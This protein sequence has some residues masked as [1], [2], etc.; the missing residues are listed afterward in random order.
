MCLGLAIREDQTAITLGGPDTT[1]RHLVK[2]PEYS[3]FLALELNSPRINY[4]YFYRN[5]KSGHLLGLEGG[6]TVRNTHTHTPARILINH[7]VVWMF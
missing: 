2:T 5:T 6:N 3:P 7:L 1:P 4:V